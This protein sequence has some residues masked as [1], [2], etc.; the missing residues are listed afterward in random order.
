MLTTHQ[1]SSFEA[2]EV[3]VAQIFIPDIQKLWLEKDLPI[4][5]Y[6]DDAPYG[7][8]VNMPTAYY[9]MAIPALQNAAL[10]KAIALA[11]D[12]DSII[13]NAMTNQSPTFAD[14]PRS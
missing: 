3:D 7:V 2:G 12:Y 8:C 5:T 9:N 6:L 14:V 10:R 13:A 1:P 4:S 11:V